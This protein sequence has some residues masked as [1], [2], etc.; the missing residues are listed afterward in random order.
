MSI[1]AFA[2][3]APAPIRQNHF[4]SAGITYQGAHSVLVCDSISE[5]AFW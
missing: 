1:R 3:T 5:N 4:R 2:S